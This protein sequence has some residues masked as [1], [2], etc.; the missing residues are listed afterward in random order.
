MKLQ[1]VNNSGSNEELL[2][3]VNFYKTLNQRLFVEEDEFTKQLQKAAMTPKQ[4]QLEKFTEKF[5][6]QRGVKENSNYII[7]RQAAEEVQQEFEKFNDKDFTLLNKIV[8]VYKTR[9]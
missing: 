7:D 8:E 6:Y 3:C 9:I 1:E 5:S 4:S 2:Q